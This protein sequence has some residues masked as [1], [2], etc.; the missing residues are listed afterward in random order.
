[1]TSVQDLGRRGYQKHGV[2]VSGAMDSYSLR[3]ANILV[4]NAEGE[5]ALEITLVGPKLKIEKGTLLALTGGDLSPKVDG[6]TLPMWRPV[7]FKQDSVL[8]FGACR[9]GCRAYLAVA[10]GYDIPEVMGSKSTYLR[11]GIGGFQGRALQQGDS[12]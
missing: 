1:M 9:A 4:G 7:Y 11:A 2:I 10:G 6:K 8:E 5:A 3:I 12:L